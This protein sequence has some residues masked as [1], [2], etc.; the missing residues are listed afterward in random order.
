MSTSG[1]EN[2]RGIDGMKWSLLS[3]EVWGSNEA[4]QQVKVSP[5]EL[6]DLNSTPGTHIV[7]RET[8]QL[9]QLTS[10]IHTYAS[11]QVHAR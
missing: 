4:A 7:E 10:G 1:K 9:P 11:W 6:N 2:V 8:H 3:V 5:A